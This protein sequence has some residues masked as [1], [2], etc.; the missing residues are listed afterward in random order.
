MSGW[1]RWETGR[2]DA[3]AEFHEDRHGV[4]L[5]PDSAGTSHART[6]SCIFPPAI[7]RPTAGVYDA[8][9]CV[10]MQGG[11]GEVKHWAFNDPPRRE[12]AYR[13]APPT[14]AE[15]RQT[16]DARD[17][18]ASDDDH[19]ERA[20]LGRRSAFAR[21][22][23]SRHGRAAGD[24]EGREGLDLAP[25]L[26]R[27]RLRHAA[28]DVDDLETHRRFRRA[29]SL[30]ADHPC[31]QFSLYRPGDQGYRRRNALSIR[32]RARG[33]EEV[34]GK[35][36]SIIRRSSDNLLRPLPLCRDSSALSRRS[37]RS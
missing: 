37:W 16:A 21:A 17:R 34:V 19:A 11:Q 3:S 31:V 2:A 7:C 25:R 26:S 29:M 23:A 18:P 12:G 22:D 15:Y 1:R 9:R 8:V 35:T 20:D 33:T 27:Q 28:D 6:S 24:L 32:R 14:P 10:V 4:V 36:L 13:D 5:Q 30:L